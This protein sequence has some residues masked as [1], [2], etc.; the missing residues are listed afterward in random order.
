M[1]IK[2]R[3]FWIE[4]LLEHSLTEETRI[5]LNLQERPDAVYIPLNTH[6]QELHRP[7][8]ILPRGTPIHK[9]FDDAAGELLILGAPG[10]G[11]T[12][13]LLELL[14]TLIDPA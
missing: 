10:A 9:V 2:V 4:G 6:V 14:R 5:A 13:L 1:L 11:K 12:T 7:A 3:K 8:Q